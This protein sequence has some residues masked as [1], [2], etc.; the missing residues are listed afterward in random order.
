[1]AS[2]GALPV[3]SAKPKVYKRIAVGHID[4]AVAGGQVHASGIGI[5]RGVVDDGV[6]GH[7]RHWNHRPPGHWTLT[8]AVAAPDP[9][10]SASSDGSRE[11]VFLEKIYSLEFNS[12]ENNRYHPATGRSAAPPALP[13]RQGGRCA[14]FLLRC[15]SSSSAPMSG[16]SVGRGSLSKSSL[17]RPGRRRATHVE[18]R[19]TQIDVVVQQSLDCRRSIRLDQ[20]QRTVGHLD[21]VA[22]FVEGTRGLQGGELLNLQVIPAAVEVRVDEVRI[23]RDVAGV[24]TR[25]I[26]QQREQRPEGIPS[27]PQQ[28]ARPVPPGRR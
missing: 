18:G 11:G 6:T 15:Y 8:T 16:P 24:L 4:K 13:A 20:R 27:R 1:M 17:N 26:G 14:W 23:T 21:E 9:P 2:V 28:T 22:A 5:D 3:L 7:S 10:S 19:R 25:R 12:Y